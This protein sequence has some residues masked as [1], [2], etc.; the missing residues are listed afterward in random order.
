VTRKKASSP[1]AP[2][3]P[4]WFPGRGRLLLAPSSPGLFYSTKLRARLAWWKD[5]VNFA[6]S[7]VIRYIEKGVTV[8]FDTPMKPL[9][10]APR[11]IDDKD[12]PFVLKDLLE[13]RRGGAYCDLAP[14]G[15]EYLSRSRVHTV[16][17]GKQ[18]FVHALC[19]LNEVT[20]KRP[21]KYDLLRDLHR[22]IK[23]NCWMLS[24]DAEKAFWS[25]PIA[26]ASRK[27][28]SS[29]FAL[30]AFYTS[31]GRETFV[32]LQPGGYWVLRPQ[33]PADLPACPTAFT[34][35]AL[36]HFYY[37]VVEMSHQSTPFGWTS[38]PRIWVSVCRVVVAALRRAGMTVFVFVD[39]FLIALD[40]QEEAQR[41]KV[42]VEEIFLASGLT[43]AP[44]KG[45]WEP[46]QTLVDHLG[47]EICSIG[48]GLISLPE[49]RCRHVRSL[50]KSLL[51]ESA[52]NKRRVPSDLL[53][54][55]TGTAIS[56]CEAVSQARF[57]LRS[58]FDDQ[59]QWLPFSTLSRAALRD[60]RWWLTL[61]S[62]HPGNGKPIWPDPPTISMYTDASGRTGFGSVLALHKEA[63]RVHG[64]FWQPQD[65]LDIICVKEMKAVKFGLLEHK[66]ALQ[67]QV[68]LLH[69]DNQA[70][71]G[72]LRNFSSSCPAMMVEL[73]EILAIL[74]LYNIRFQVVYVRSADNLADAPSRLRGLDMWSLRPS[75]QRQVLARAQHHLGSLVDTDPFAC[76]SSKVASI[77]ATPL[78][79][80]QAAAFDGLLLDWT[81]PHTVWL[82]PPWDLL[83]AV[84]AKIFDKG[85]T[86]VLIYP[87][88]PLQPWFELA[89]SLPGLHFSLPPPRFS[90]LAH[91][92]GTVEPFTNH[93]VAL[94]VVV[95]R[96]PPSSIELQAPVV[97]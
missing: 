51:C 1:K 6:P 44:S 50:A 20:T 85:A 90:V 15:H 65:L 62:A 70:V 84:L 17:S 4:R 89:A 34:P 36:R 19:G 76:R 97:V 10:L 23:P 53:R 13:G 26:P 73:R 75:L 86:G 96:Q 71:V 47:Y 32:P 45:Q 43:R 7:R 29:H 63:Y 52:R 77:Y 69:Q 54:R 78:H 21:T 22:V 59:Q 27:Y 57:R 58:L 93:A 49:R 46:S 42:I 74:D 39:D 16:G 83:P 56:S 79:D 91:H 72:A 41:A 5:P 88:W 3:A 64:T 95:F 24:A 68:V 92:P 2:L 80:L 48:K 66:D 30:P 11:F 31:Q 38:S 35:P 81:P 33:A 40:S 60:L 14:G 61:D 82:N 37:Q 25:V 18:R 12:I 28:M 8:E 67:G 87:L 94:R 9:R 55:F